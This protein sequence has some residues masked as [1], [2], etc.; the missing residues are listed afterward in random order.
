MKVIQAPHRVDWK[1]PVTIFLAGS[2][3]MGAASEWQQEA[4]ELFEELIPKRLNGKYQILNPR[5]DDWDNTVLNDFEDPVFSQ[6][7]NWELRGLRESDL[8][9][10]YFDPGTVSPITLL[11]L[12]AF[13][14]KMV[15]VCPEGY[16]KK[17]NVDIFCDANR[18]AQKGD[19]REAV[20]LIIKRTKTRAS[21]KY[22]Y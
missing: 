13:A 14:H 21:C 16:E 6:Q 9:L 17:G 18:I 8:V 20:K 4:I 12:G 22:A 3:E 11:E 2:I 19:L 15:V 5:R 7:V 1:A 10:T